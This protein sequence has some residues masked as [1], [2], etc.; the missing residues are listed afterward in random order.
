MSCELSSWR[1]QCSAQIPLSIKVSWG[2]L[3]PGAALL[4]GTFPENVSWET[5]TLTS[6]SLDTRA[7]GSAV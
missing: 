1:R 5:W 7:G 4:P 6:C 3:F 2:C